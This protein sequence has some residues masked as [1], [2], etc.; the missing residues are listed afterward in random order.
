MFDTDINHKLTSSHCGLMAHL[1]EH[2]YQYNC[3]EGQGIMSLIAFRDK[4][5]PEYHIFDPLSSVTNSSNFLIFFIFFR[6]L[7]YTGR[8]MLPSKK[9]QRSVVFYWDACGNPV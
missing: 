4:R 7:A 8:K 3:G 1:V 6:V 2:H 9:T 5:L